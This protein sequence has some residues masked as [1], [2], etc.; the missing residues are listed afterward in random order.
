MSPL[1]LIVRFQK[2]FH[3]LCV[4]FLREIVQALIP[5]DSKSNY[6][7]H[8]EY[9]VR[10]LKS[11]KQNMA[12]DI[13]YIY[14]SEHVPSTSEIETKVDPRRIKEDL[15]SIFYQNVCLYFPFMSI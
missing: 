9:S 8:L 2:L 6:D 15:I 12:V 14:P 10:D 4:L 11:Y 3:Y 13:V 5:P 7:L 1:L